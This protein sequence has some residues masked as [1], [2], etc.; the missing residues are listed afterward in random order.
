MFNART[1]LD[2]GAALY[3]LKYAQESGIQMVSQNEYINRIAYSRDTTSSG[4]EYQAAQFNTVND[5]NETARELL[6]MYH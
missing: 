6:A 5:Y 4:L 2:F 1:L 3:N